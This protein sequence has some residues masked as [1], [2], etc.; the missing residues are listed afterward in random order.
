MTLP[1]VTAPAAPTSVRPIRRVVVAALALGLAL[2]LAFAFGYWVGK[3][4]TL[5][6]Q[7]YLQLGPALPAVTASSTRERRAPGTSNVRRPSQRSS[8]ESCG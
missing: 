6:E 3:P 8:A 1:A 5:D 4:L 7:E 2:R